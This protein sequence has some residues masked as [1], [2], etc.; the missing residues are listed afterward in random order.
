MNPSCGGSPFN[1]RPEYKGTNRV[2]PAESSVEVRVPV[3][4]G[5]RASGQPTADLPLLGIRFDY[6]NRTH[7]PQLVERYVLQILEGKTPEQLGAYLPPPE[8]QLDNV[9]VPIPRDVRHPEVPPSRRAD[10]R[11]GGG[12]GG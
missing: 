9:V 10:A 2:Y 4:V 11:A 1:V 5:T 12:A 6:P 3:V 8:V 7:L